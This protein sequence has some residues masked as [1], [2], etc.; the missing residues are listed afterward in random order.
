MNKMSSPELYK[1]LSLALCKQA[2]EQNRQALELYRQALALT[3]SIEAQK[4]LRMAFGRFGRNLRKQQAPEP[5]EPASLARK[6]SFRNFLKRLHSYRC[7]DRDHNGYYRFQSC[8]RRR[9]RLARK[10]Q[11]VPD[12]RNC[13]RL[14]RHRHS[15]IVHYCDH[16][17]KLKALIL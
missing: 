8:E 3:H 7:Y 5:L 1:L 11:P 9:P 14:R 10:T 2:P 16:Q 4:L 12:R 15:H 17:R 6:R 13:R